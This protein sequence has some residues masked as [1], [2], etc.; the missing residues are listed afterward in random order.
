MDSFRRHVLICDPY[1]S[2]EE[3]D[4]WRKITNGIAAS[5]MKVNSPH[6]LFEIGNDLSVILENRAAGI[7]PLGTYVTRTMHSVR[8]EKS[9]E[10][11]PLYSAV[12]AMLAVYRVLGGGGE[13]KRG[14]AAVAVWSALSFGAPLL[15]PRL[16]ALRSEI[17][18]RAEK[19]ALYMAAQVRRRVERP[20][21]QPK[22]SLAGGVRPALKRL[23]ETTDGWRKN[24]ALDRDE[25]RLLRWL[26]ADKCIGLTRGFGDIDVPATAALA[27]GLELGG[28]L[29][30]FP[31]Q[32]HFRLGAHFVR[33]SG[34]L[35]LPQLVEVVGE[36]RRPLAASYGESIRGGQVACR[37]PA[38][39]GTERGASAG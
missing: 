7:G 34:S 18:R 24:E 26:L 36:D 25:I 3:M 23:Q 17:L 1:P 30:T 12:C 28:L 10:D 19:T 9:R 29:S 33:E 5:V 21:E 35:D 4:G 31:E 13:V 39:E 27:A 2:A 6:T 22:T 16:E 32:T 14:V 37:I 11:N 8:P 15:E 38:N 20:A